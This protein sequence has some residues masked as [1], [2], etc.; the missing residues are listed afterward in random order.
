MERIDATMGL[1]EL[2]SIFYRYGKI[3]GINYCDI[4]RCLLLLIDAHLVHGKPGTCN[5]AFVKFVRIDDAVKAKSEL[6]YAR[7]FVVYYAR[8]FTRYL[9]P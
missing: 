9:Q 7:P 1:D 5:F 2:L 8:V 3:E 6:Y 4:I